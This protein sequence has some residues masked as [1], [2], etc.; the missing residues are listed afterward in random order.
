MAAG[1]LSA[2]GSTPN[3]QADN[4]VDD[5]FDFIYGSSTEALMDKIS[6]SQAA[7]AD[8]HNDKIDNITG[9]KGTKAASVDVKSVIS[10]GGGSETV[11]V[12]VN[13]GVIT[14]SGSDAGQINTLAE[15]IDSV[16]VD[17]VIA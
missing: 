10:G 8:D 3:N 6:D 7:A 17:G 4:A 15:R 2:C 12:A 5:E 1:L 16:S 14:L 9:A 13:N 11:T